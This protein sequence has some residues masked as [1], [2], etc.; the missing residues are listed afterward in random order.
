MDL[1]SFRQQYDQLP[2]LSARTDL[3]LR[4]AE[5]AMQSHPDELRPLLTDCG[6]GC[7][8]E[9]LTVE[10]ALCDRVLGWMAVDRADYPAAL[11]FF[12]RAEE[13]LV[14]A[15]DTAG[16]LKVLNGIGSVHMGQ[17]RFEAALSVF[18]RALALAEGLGDR[19]QAVVVE[20]NIGE[21]LIGLRQ[22]ADAADHLSRSW[23][24]G[25]LRPLNE[26]LVLN[27]LARACLP[28]G[29][30]TEARA[31]LDRSVLL[32]RRGN[33][34]PSLAMALDLLGVLELGLGALE[35]A[36]ACLTEA[37]TVA[38]QARDRATETQAVIDL[39]WLAHRRNQ[40]EPAKQ[41][42]TEAL[43]EARAIG[44]R[45]LESEA[46]L[47]V[48]R[49]AKALG[50]WEEA[51]EAHEHY[52]ALAE[53]IHD[54]DVTR[55]V[56]QIR[57]DQVQREA[58]LYRE[59][60]RVLARLGDLGQKI[61]ASL[62]LETIILTVYESID[63]LMRADGFGLGLYDEVRGIID[64]Q[65]FLEEGQRIKPFEA[66]VAGGTFSGWCLRHR[67]DLLISDV[68]L[69]FS[70][71][72]PA[73]PVRIDTNG[74]RTRSG[75]YIPLLAEGMVLGVLSVQSYQ[76]NAYSERDRGTLKTLG[77]SIAIAIQNA[78]LFDQV[79]RLA[80]V[81]SLTGAA[82]R[83]YLFERAEEEFGRFQREKTPMA[84][85][86]VDLDHFKV[87]NDTWGHA[88]GDRVL[89]E[90]GALCLAQKRPHD[91]FGRYGGEEFALLLSGTT[92]EGAVKTAER[93]RTL[94]R[95]LALTAP[96]GEPIRLTASFGVTGFDPADEGLSR[97]FS[98]ADEALYE[99]K[100]G[101]RD[102]VVTRTA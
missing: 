89:A 28:L 51:L 65:L 56:A 22:F 24:S 83:R 63:G 93:L 18:R 80:T 37:R 88:V 90:F 55:Q 72:V 47:G 97:V 76:T 45:L 84:L 73:L 70:Q 96:E 54:E 2:T 82:T 25:L 87:L 61:T 21:T 39:G 38:H 16:Q 62:D 48:S 77:A 6:Q 15:E 91:L 67:Q 30:R 66:P 98:R 100:L 13:A 43:V 52:Y 64:Y 74:K 12:E 3:L 26:S 20:A 40:G 60:S 92:V 95:D 1:V 10:A 11:G 81:D 33:Y 14:E 79:R 71:Y 46:L 59:Q 49:A 78:R 75:L 99:A 50:Q 68:D 86:M 57:A 58:E 42:F 19:H 44:A 94:V 101:G 35:A 85:V 41:C 53:R 23:N 69:E 36:Q 29:R 27:Q 34:L 32:A 17:G 4:F 7:R 31:A 5:E 102:R 9:G 8:T